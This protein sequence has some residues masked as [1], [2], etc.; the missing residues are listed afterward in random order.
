M[1]FAAVFDGLR[2]ARYQGPLILQ[3]ARGDGELATIRRALDFLSPFLSE[4]HPEPRTM[5]LAP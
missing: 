1:R 5:N 3:V 4:P 2:Q